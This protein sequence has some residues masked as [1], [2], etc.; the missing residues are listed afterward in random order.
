MEE[1][2]VSVKLREIDLP[3]L[4][5]EQFIGRKEKIASADT[6]RSK[7]GYY[8]KVSSTV[9]DVFQRGK[10]T[11]ELRAVRIFPLYEDDK[12]NIGWGKKT[13]LAEYLLL[14]KVSSP[15][16]LVGRDII[17]QSTVKD[18]KEFLSFI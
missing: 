4:D 3:R 5:I 15:Q 6:H 10:E 12:G 18:G 8:L 14:K 16:D 9:I 7:F 2:K 13:L 17:I 1:T 11:K